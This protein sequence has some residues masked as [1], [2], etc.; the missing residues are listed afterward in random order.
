[1]SEPISAFA[2]YKSSATVKANGR[3]EK[4]KQKKQAKGKGNNK[5]QSNKLKSQANNRT[6]KKKQS[7]INNNKNKKKQQPQ[8]KGKKPSSS[9]SNGAAILSGTENGVEMNTTDDAVYADEYTM[10]DSS[11]GSS[12]DEAPSNSSP[13]QQ[14]ASEEAH[15]DDDDEENY[16]NEPEFSLEALQ[17][18]TKKKQAEK[19]RLKQQQRRN[20][21]AVASSSLNGTTDSSPPASKSRKLSESAAKAPSSPAGTNHIVHMNSIL[22]GKRMF[23]WL[24][25]PVTVEDFLDKYWEKNVCVI[26]RKQPQYYSHLM[27]FPMIDEMLLQNHVEFTK[28]IDI[29]SYKN[30]VRETLNPEGR[31]L[32]AAVW[33]QYGQG[34]SI[35]VLNP[36]TFLPDVYALCSTLQ[37]FFHCMVGANAYLTPPDSQGF[38][39][40]YDDIEAFV[41]QVEGRKRWRL[42]KPRNSKEQLP[43]YSSPNFKQEEIGTPILETV[44]HPGDVLYFPRGTIHQ[45]FTEP[46]YHSLHITLSVYQKQSYADLFEK[47]MPLMLE[48]AIASDVNMRRGLPLHTFQNAGLAFSEVD[49]KERAEFVKS[50]S[51]RL[52]TMVRESMLTELVDAAVDQVAKKFQHE[53]LPPQ[54]FPAERKRTIFGSRSMPNERGECLCDY[55]ID[56]RTNVRLLRAHI[57]RLVREDGGAVR[58]Y[59]HLDNSKEY[60]EYEPNYIEI[61]P[62]EAASVE[63]LIKSYPAY[64]GVSQLPLADDEHKLQVV[65][66]L[67]ERGLLMMEKPF[68]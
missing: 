15:D 31:A 21:I 52:R 57:M 61:D 11:V 54:I 49:T 22:E 28:N 33:D 13:Q 10:D 56:L 41:V 51:D 19:R 12:G 65:S 36:Q 8:V 20:T 1:M 45:A 62:Q 38:A 63:V 44:L 58:I 37:E 7:N 43:R 48:K 6:L 3:K 50:V 16:E 34:C 67:W 66:A 42:Y 14:Q 2:V 46:G 47:L 39:P 35:R 5:H 32:P 55:E 25:Q 27:S 30:G 40:H 24:L 23:G 60:C 59:Y 17:E 26:K 68:K 4:Q 9:P 64:V 53:A 18:F 29:T